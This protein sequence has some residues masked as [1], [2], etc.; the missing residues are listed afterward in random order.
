MQISTTGNKILVELDHEEA[1]A[2]R[3][4]LGDIWASK[5]STA[6]DRLHSLLEDTTAVTEEAAR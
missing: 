4:D 6:G 2:V 3:D 1:A 5:V